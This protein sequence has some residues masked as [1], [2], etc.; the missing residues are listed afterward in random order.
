MTRVLVVANRTASTLAL[1]AE[2]A[3]GPAR[4]PHVTGTS[5]CATC[6]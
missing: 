2:S 5:S 4:T 1:L 6:S 3:S